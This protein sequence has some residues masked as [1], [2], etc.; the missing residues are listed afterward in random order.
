MKLLD[1][2]QKMIDEITMQER[3]LK[4]HKGCGILLPLFTSDLSEGQQ[5]LTWFRMDIAPILIQKY[6]YPLQ[7]PEPDCVVE[8][9]QCYLRMNSNDNDEPIKSKISSPR[10]LHSEHPKE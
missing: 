9:N 7:L 6:S 4:A 1:W 10:L 2:Q 5:R 3:A 8:C